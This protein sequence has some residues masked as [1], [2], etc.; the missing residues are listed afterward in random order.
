EL[1]LEELFKYEYRLSESNPVLVNIRVIC[2]NTALNG[3]KFKEMN[4]YWYGASSDKVK[5]E[6]PKVKKITGEIVNSPADSEYFTRF[7]GIYSI[8]EQN[9]PISIKLHQKESDLENK[10]VILYC[11]KVKVGETLED[12]IKRSMMSDFGL[13]L[14]SYR[15]CSW[16]ID[17][18][19]NK[20]GQSLPRIGVM[21]YVKY[22]PIEDKKAAG[23]FVS[24]VKRESE[25]LK[26]KL[27]PEAL[28]WIKNDSTNSL[29]INRF[30]NK[31]EA[32]VFIEKL[33]MLGALEV[34]VKNIKQKIEVEKFGDILVVV[35]PENV[36]VRQK[37]FS[38]YYEEM[39]RKVPGKGWIADDGERELV[40]R[41]D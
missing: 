22:G 31:E 41:W 1:G 16:V 35:L 15:A 37:I 8:N 34:R 27:D 21:A 14:L 11:D 29:A 6:T 39:T 24:W 40:F 20:L 17:E 12:S 38:L 23:C 33:Y 19:K 7:L 4:L 9:E 32:R 30:T 28:G 10:E 26:F 25:L 36:E 13:E 2:K 18:A 5:N 3:R